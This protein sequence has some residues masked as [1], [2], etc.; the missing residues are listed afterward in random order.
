MS[1][2]WNIKNNNSEPYGWS[3][4]EKAG[5]ARGAAPKRRG[6]GFYASGRE[7]VASVPRVKA[8]KPKAQWG[9]DG[10]SLGRIL[11][12]GGMITAMKVPL[13]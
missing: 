8:W 5:R 9:R 7:D 12:K 1:R 3:S 10:R 6:A 4:Q 11:A 13:K 2:I